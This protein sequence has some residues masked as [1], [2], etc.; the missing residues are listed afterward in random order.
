MKTFR[1][2]DNQSESCK[3]IQSVPTAQGLQFSSN[4]RM[5][6]FYLGTGQEMMAREAQ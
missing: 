4:G 6:L 3:N 2:G 5:R 1:G